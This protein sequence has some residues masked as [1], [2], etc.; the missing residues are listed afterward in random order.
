MRGGSGARLALIAIVAVLA[1]LVWRGLPLIERT[2][3][4]PAAPQLIVARGDLADSEQSTIAL[5]EGAKDSVVSITTENRV[6]DFWTR[7][8][9]NVPL[10][11]GSGFLWDR[12]GHVVTNNHVIAGATSAIVRL[13][14]GEAFPARLVGTASG[15]DLAVLRIDAGPQ[16]PAPLP[17]GGSADLRVGQSVF[18][19]GNPFGLDWTLTTGIVSALGRE[20]PGER[21]TSIRGLIQT[22]AAINPGN[23]GG[24]LLDSAGLLIGVNTAIYSPSGASV[25]I[26]FAVPVDTVNR[27]VP[28]LIATGRY[29]PPTMGVLFDPRGDALLRRAG[30]TGV[31]VLDVVPGSPAAAAGLRPL[32]VTRDGRLRL[33]DVIVALDGAAIRDSADL[34]AALD[35]REAGATVE[36]GLLRGGGRTEVSLVLAEGG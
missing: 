25:G 36:L 35:I 19:I 29:A 27:V 9:V 26:G 23:S 4:P 33:G 17:L 16:Q 30:M 31:P 3:A 21:G 18:A 22:D 24:P 12:Q 28:Q 34:G 32:G 8:A 7:D 1:V 6:V 2:L 15:H 20:I 11:S 10:G 5:F 14:D 13:A